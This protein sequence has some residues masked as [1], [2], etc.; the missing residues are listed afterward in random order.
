MAREEREIESGIRA[1]KTA[2]GQQK[3]MK[4]RRK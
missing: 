1:K 4:T 3:C 2:L